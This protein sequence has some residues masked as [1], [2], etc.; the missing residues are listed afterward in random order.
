[1]RSGRRRSFR[2]PSSTGAKGMRQAKCAG[3]EL[4]DAVELLCA[5]R[6]CHVSARSVQAPALRSRPLSP[7][8]D[9]TC[10]NRYHN[11]IGISIS[12]HRCDA[13]SC[14][15]IFGSL[16]IGQSACRRQG[17]DWPSRGTDQRFRCWDG[18]SGSPL[19]RPWATQSDIDG[20]T[21]ERPQHAKKPGAIRRRA[22]DVRSGTETKPRRH[23]R[24]GFVAQNGHGWSAVARRRAASSSSGQGPKCEPPCGPSQRQWRSSPCS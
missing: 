10:R 8:N 11:P 13:F 22:V 17:A 15:L 7:A 21:T 24:R 16:T 9:D 23:G 6:S 12:M 14:R 18:G 20:G 4:L 19:R 1:M 3:K 2:L 5:C